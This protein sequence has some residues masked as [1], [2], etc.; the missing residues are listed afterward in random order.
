MWQIPLKSDIRDEC[1]G[2]YQRLALAW[3][4]L[5][6]ALEQ[7]AAQVKLPPPSPPKEAAAE[8]DVDP[9]EAVAPPTKK[10]LAAAAARAKAGDG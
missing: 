4:S 7:P 10:E 1:S 6:D 9:A 2:N 8:D 3:L 5:P